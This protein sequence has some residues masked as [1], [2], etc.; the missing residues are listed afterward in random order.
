MISYLTLQ[1]S[2]IGFTKCICASIHAHDKAYLYCDDLIGKAIHA[3][4][5][6]QPGCIATEGVRDRVNA[7]PIQSWDSGIGVH[8]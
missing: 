3:S 1:V 5:R 4:A 6:L 2:V 8:E 7:W